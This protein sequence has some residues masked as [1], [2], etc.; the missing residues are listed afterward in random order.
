ML[1]RSVWPD[2][3][4]TATSTS[5]SQRKP[6]MCPA[7]VFA[8]SVVAPP[9]LAKRE[10]LAAYGGDGGPFAGK[11]SR[12]SMMWLRAV[13]SGVVHVGLGQASGGS[14]KASHT[15]E[16]SSQKLRRSAAAS[17]IASGVPV[18][19]EPASGVAT[20]SPSPPR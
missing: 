16:A 8:I 20:K 2:A 17:P 12:V 5:S 19:S 4:R 11:T 7:Y 9:S 15:H 18:A 10:K 13:G 1:T 14:S 3:A 6:V